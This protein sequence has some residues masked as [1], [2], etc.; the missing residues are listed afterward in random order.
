MR[1][2]NQR[3]N[4]PQFRTIVFLNDALLLFTLSSTVYSFGTRLLDLLSWTRISNTQTGANEFNLI[5][6]M[7]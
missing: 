2:L 4:D 7:W 6:T 5:L 3:A 1:S